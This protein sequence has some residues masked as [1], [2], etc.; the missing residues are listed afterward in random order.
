MFVSFSEAN[1]KAQVVTITQDRRVTFLGAIATDLRARRGFS[2]A[3]LNM[4]HLV[5]LRDDDA[6]RAACRAQE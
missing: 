5:K 1:K 6:F 2:V 3:T 4:D